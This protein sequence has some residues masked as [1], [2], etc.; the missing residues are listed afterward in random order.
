MHDAEAARGAARAYL[1]R[2][3]ARTARPARSPDPARWGGADRQRVAMNSAGERAARAV[4]ASPCAVPGAAAAPSPDRS[5]GYRRVR[6]TAVWLSLLAVGAPA[7]VCR[8]RWRSAAPQPIGV[9][10][11]AGSR[12]AGE[13]KRELSA[14]NLASVSMVA[15]D[16]DWPAGDDRPGLDSLSAGRGRRLQRRPHDRLFAR[17]DHRPRRGPLRAELRSQRSPGAA[18]R[19][20]GGGRRACARSAR[21]AAPPPA[22]RRPASLP[23]STPALAPVSRGRRRAG[24]GVGAGPIALASAPVR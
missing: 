10:A 7:C 17:R 16:R 22:P 1:A 20:P 14:A 18:P 8:N 19:L 13:L 12:L 21:P 3:P 6:R 5:A 11:P 4:P 24:S 15:S 2:A 9:I 23:P